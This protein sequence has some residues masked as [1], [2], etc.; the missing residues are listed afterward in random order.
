[1]PDTDQ[2]RVRSLALLRSGLLLVVL[3]VLGVN[4][5]AATEF[6]SRDHYQKPDDTRHILVL[7]SSH[8]GYGWTDSI[9]AGI[10]SVMQAAPENIAAA[11]AMTCQRRI[12]AQPLLS[13]VDD[14]VRRGNRTGENS[15]STHMYVGLYQ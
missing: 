8:R 14:V 6:R 7:H 10:E 1:M 4:E 2:L 9:M 13:G 5:V 12:A 15:T 11:N 3:A